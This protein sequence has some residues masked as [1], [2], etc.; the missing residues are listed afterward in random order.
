MAGTLF[1]TTTGWGG[2]EVTKIK[3]VG[4]CGGRLQRPLLSPHFRLLSSVH[5]WYVCDFAR[6]WPPSPPTAAPGCHL[7]FQFRPELVLRFPTPLCSD[8]FSRF[9]P[10]RQR[11]EQNMRVHHAGAYLRQEVSPCP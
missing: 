10:P 2:Q 5:R 9:L 7:C 4:C 11:S 1:G 8:A 3:L 6:V